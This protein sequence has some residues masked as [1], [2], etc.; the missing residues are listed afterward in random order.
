MKN[1]L[2]IL[3]QVVQPEPLV[4]TVVLCATA[5]R[6]PGVMLL[7]ESARLTV[8]RGGSHQHAL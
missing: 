4:R 6:T 2:L 5:M 8:L 3:F 1:K 7:L